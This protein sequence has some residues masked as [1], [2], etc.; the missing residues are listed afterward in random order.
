[1]AALVGKD[2]KVM[3]GTA[4][5]AQAD[6]WSL[7]TPATLLETTNFGSAGWKEYIAG[8]KEWNGSFECNFDPTDT[9]G[10]VALR[11]AWQNGTTVSLKLYVN[12]TNY[13]SGNA[14]IENMP[15]SSPV[16]E[17]VRVTVNFRGSGQL[18]Y[19]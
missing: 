15:V 1:M 11:T 16:G 13:Y 9:T 5:V 17:K 12:A 3:I 4:Q 10:Q 19:S 8:L 18:A 7:D 2:A 6:T 14:L